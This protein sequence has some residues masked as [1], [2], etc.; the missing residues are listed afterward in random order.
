M[1][2]VLNLLD[3]LVVLFSFECY[4]VISLYFTLLRS[5]FLYIGLNFLNGFISA[6]QKSNDANLA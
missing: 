6:S 4:E 5:T 2:K 1:T 3:D